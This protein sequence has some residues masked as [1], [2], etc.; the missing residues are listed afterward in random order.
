MIE[1]VQVIDRNYRYLYLNK[2]ACA[3]GKKSHAE[4]IGQNMLEKYPGIE[5][6]E[7]YGLITN[8][9]SD[10]K[11]HELINKF[12][13][14][15]GGVGYFEIRVQAIPDGVL[16]MSF[17]VTLE[18][19]AARDRR[20][21]EKLEAELQVAR[22]TQLSLLPQQPPS[23]R[24]LNVAWRFMPIE[25]VGGDLFDF[26]TIDQHK[27][28]VMIGDVAGHGVPSAM[29]AAMLKVACIDSLNKNYEPKFFLESINQAIGDLSVNLFATGAYCLIDTNEMSVSAGSAGHPQMLILSRNGSVKKL[30]TSGPI[31]G[32]SKEIPFETQTLPIQSGDIMLLYTDGIIECRN[33]DGID[34]GE[35]RL[36]QQLAEMANMSA[37]QICAKLLQHI[38]DWLGDEPWED[39][40]TMIA[41]EVKNE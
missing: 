11:F 23:I 14:P 39:D 1:G 6:T 19:R 25:A 24:K 33:Q 37:E 31:L 2:A 12:D 35:A 38:S 17:D 36:K 28:G 4:L 8:C 18:R 27:L 20:E 26:Y 7:I 16:V 10:G 29:V 3:H 41:I 30:S 9:F 21:L 22:E 34:F 40:A 15:D 5:S 32:I 13:Y